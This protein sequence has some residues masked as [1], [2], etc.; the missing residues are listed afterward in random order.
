[1]RSAFFRSALILL[2]VMTIA[3]VAAAA[4][5]PVPLIYPLP[6]SAT[7]PGGPAFTL[8]VNGTGFVSG[9][10]V[11]WN[12][13]ALTTTFVSSSQVTA[14]VPAANIASP[15]TAEITV[16]NPAPGGG[17]SNIGYFQV[18]NATAGLAFNDSPMPNIGPSGWSPAVGDFRGNGKVDIV[19]G[20]P[21][22]PNSPQ[23]AVQILLGN[24]DGTF[25][26]PATVT[27]TPVGTKP[28]FIGVGD[29][30][31]DGK[32]DLVV[33]YFGNSNGINEFG[34]SA[35]LGNGDGTFQAPLTVFD[36]SN[37]DDQ[38]FGSWVADV[39]GDGI[40]DLASTCGAG[41]CVYLG[42]GNG[43]F[44][45]QFT[46]RM[47]VS[48]TW[49][50]PLYG[51]CGPLAVN[52]LTL[53]DFHK[54]GKLDIVATVDPD[55]LVMLP[56]NGDGTFG[57][58]SLLYGLS[59]NG[60]GSVVTADFDNDGNLDLAVSYYNDNPP[61][62][63]SN[64]TVGVVGVLRGN[65]NGTFQAPMTLTGLPQPYLGVPIPL[66]LGDFNGDGHTD[67][68]ENNVVI[69][70]G[71][72]NG[73]FSYSVIPMPYGASVVGDFNGDGRL[74]VAGWD[75]PGT[76]NLLH[77]EMQAAPP[78]DFKGSINPTYQSVT[79]GTSASYTVTVT[80]IDGF[81]GTVQF[82]ASGLPAG[83]T[84]TFNPPTVTGS[85]ST[86]A[87]ITT[88]SSTPN[89]SYSITLTGTSGSLV[90]AGAVALN[91][92]PSGTNFADFT[93]SLQ[94]TYTTTTP[95][96]TGSLNMQI[97]PLNGF[98]SDVSM[99]V[100][101]L[102]AGATA[103][104]NPTVVTGGSGWTVLSVTTAS[105]TPTATYPLVITATGGGK[106]HS[107]TIVLNVGPAG[108]DFTDF[109][110]SITPLSQTV[111]V[112]QS[113]TFTANVQ[114][115]YGTGCVS[116]QAIN[117][118]PNSTALYDRSTPICGASASTVLT[119]ATSPQTPVGTYTM[120]IQGFSSGGFTHSKNITVTVTP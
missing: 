112:G 14:S 9:A 3:G 120:T 7:A 70:I 76:I 51:N 23:N 114:L 78:V 108:T 35:L 47:P 104:F 6:V 69:L 63:R 72:G 59:A 117:T 82:S 91:V 100:S 83:T 5:N 89:G 92:G 16:T 75:Y 45:R 94:S 30:N 20:Q 81:A 33:S 29:F 40:P 19:M 101:G 60:T 116:L 57:A 56:G 17:K 26:A 18:T 2:A 50:R 22:T 98:T 67:L 97:I 110:G 49:G 99:S 58:L 4:N 111:K 43:T 48:C 71:N 103:A 24:G 44:R 113:T 73:P 80:A 77:V 55:Y 54:N 107:N 119:V 28:E 11:N 39:N 84:A 41:I 32:L 87:T 21:V 34:E 25:Q 88:S 61:Q 8:T 105:S 96:G 27:A 74:D 64:A 115:L 66:V 52:S 79:P 62:P 15:G 93:G 1:M 86:T 118:P 42:N 102:P 65:G 38:V 37:V 53:G 85:G 106:A 68:L 12:G 46:Y 109:T 13:T 31:G 95:G 90:H 10:L 36:S